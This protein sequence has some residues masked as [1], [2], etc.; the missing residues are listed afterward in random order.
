MQALRGHS[1]HLQG[2]YIALIVVVT[3]TSEKRR[4]VKFHNKKHTI[5]VLPTSPN[6]QLEMES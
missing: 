6:N 3:C 1:N 4:I 5:E 2:Q